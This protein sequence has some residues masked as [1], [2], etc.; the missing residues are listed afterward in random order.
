M[1]MAAWEDAEGVEEIDGNH[2]LAVVIQA[3]GTAISGTS[4]V[5]WLPGSTFF[6]YM[7]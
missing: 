6:S 3:R 2:R 5:V 1:P 4:Q 7:F